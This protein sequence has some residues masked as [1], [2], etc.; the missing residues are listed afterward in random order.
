MFDAQITGNTRR[1]VDARDRVTVD[2]RGFGSRLS[3]EAAKRHMTSAALVRH[4]LVALLGQAPSD[5]IDR[6]ADG[7][8]HETGQPPL[9]KVTLRMSAVHAGLLA[10]RSHAADVS[11][12]RYIAS[13][14][15]GMPAPPRPTDHSQ[16]V[17]ALLT[18]SDRLAVL[19]ADLSAFVRLVGR[20]P[21]GQLEP[22]RASIQALAT[23]VRAHLTTAAELVASL[24]PSRSRQ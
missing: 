9:T 19:A 12:G 21:N 16:T 20:V 3:V 24:R 1:T 6:H 23:D 13:L 4:A 15:D 22:Y 14:L 2:L 8:P 7:V 11:Q 17:A 10:T 18:S 5:G